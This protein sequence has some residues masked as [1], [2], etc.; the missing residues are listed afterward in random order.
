MIKNF[1]L[2]FLLIFILGCSPR[3]GPKTRYYEKDGEQWRESNIYY[4]PNGKKT[5]VQIDQYKGNS[6]YES[7]VFYEIWPNGDCKFVSKEGFYKYR[8]GK[9]QLIGDSIKVPDNII[10]ESIDSNHNMVTFYYK[11]GEKVPYTLGKRDGIVETIYGGDNP[12][13]YKWEN[14]EKVLVRELSQS[15]KAFVNNLTQKISGYVSPIFDISPDG[16]KIVISKSKEGT[17]HLFEFSLKDKTLSKLTTNEGEYY[18]RP[19]YS[20]K[21]DKILFLKKDLEKQKS[22]ICIFDVQ[23]KV[24]S[25]ITNDS[26]YVT[27]AVFHPSE[28]KIIYCGAEF[29]GSYSPVARKAPHDLDL[30]SVLIDGKNN[31]KLTNLSAYELSSI[32]LSQTGDSVLCKL[33][34]KKYGGIF[35][36]SLADTSIINKIE[37]I[38][39]PRPQIGNS[40][41][42]NPNY[43]NDF[44]SIAFTAPYQ[45]YTLDLETNTCREVWSTFRKDTQAM[46]IHSKFFESNEK[47][48]F[49]TIKIENRQY[50]K[51]ADLMIIDLNTNEIKEIDIN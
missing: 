15:D 29:I 17:S 21:G 8:D 22:N 2:L 46:V 37:A 39:N 6:L 33:T 35:V 14:G 18:S 4:Y 38:N 41:Y 40:F 27:E 48:L 3:I 11:D 49:S 16:Q 44:K 42:S 10:V 32:S 43:S 12:G 45:L 26:I 13:V 19:V 23:S 25:I 34:E 5:L 36:L 30:Y 28:N 51:N 20:K 9:Y 7:L 50:S 47:I 1:N 31:R 24:I